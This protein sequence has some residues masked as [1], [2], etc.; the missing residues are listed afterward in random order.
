MSQNEA[1]IKIWIHTAFIFQIIKVVNFENLLDFIYKPIFLETFAMTRLTEKKRL[2][3]KKKAAPLATERVHALLKTKITPVTNLLL[4]KNK[5]TSGA[6]SK[7]INN[8]LP[9][10][11][12]I[13]ADSGTNKKFSVFEVSSINPFEPMI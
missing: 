12:N 10:I 5:T 9:A 2:V 7:S 8:H 1:S 11:V 6:K 13:L 4:E 3:A